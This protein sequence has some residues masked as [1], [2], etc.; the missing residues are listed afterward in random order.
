MVITTMTESKVDPVPSS[1][2]LLIEDDQPT[3][4]LYQ[5]ELSQDY[6]VLACESGNEALSLLNSYPVRAIILE[7]GLHDGQGWTLL[8]TLQM[9]QQTDNTGSHIIICSTLDER[10]RGLELGAEVY[11]IK[12]VLP[13]TLL[14]VVREIVRSHNKI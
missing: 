11:L 5:R 12:P 8:A 1:A 14:G 7:P 10:R 13:T 3:R 9:L 4:D 2:I 6:Q